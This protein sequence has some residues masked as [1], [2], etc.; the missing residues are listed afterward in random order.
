[1][2]E[3]AVIHVIHHFH[4]SNQHVITEKIQFYSN[5]VNDARERGRIKKSPSSSC[6]ITQEIAL[7]KV[8]SVHCLFLL[9][10]ECMFDLERVCHCQ[11]HDAWT[12]LSPTL[13]RQ[14][15]SSQNQQIPQKLQIHRQP[16]DRHQF[17]IT[18][19]NIINNHLQNL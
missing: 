6:W 9:L 1:M 3:I 19:S 13:H 4:S 2:N 8:D 12:Q 14:D 11:S 10:R 5:Y 7:Q 18:M 15:G 17:S 16:S